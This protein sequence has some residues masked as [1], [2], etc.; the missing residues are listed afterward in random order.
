[1][2]MEKSSI[3]SIG[4]VSQTRQILSS[5]TTELKKSLIFRERTRT[6]DEEPETKNNKRQ[7]PI[8]MRQRRDNVT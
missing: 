8:T 1:M 6:P 7:K 4:K 3:N 5:R 2:T